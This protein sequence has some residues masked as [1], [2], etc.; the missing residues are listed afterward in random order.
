MFGVDN[1]FMCTGSLITP[2]Y[3]IS[4]AHCNNLV[5]QDGDREANRRECVRMTEAGRQYSNYPYFKHL[6][7]KCK[8]L[9]SGDFEIRTE[10]KG[11]AWMGVNDVNR[12]SA[13]N[14]R[15]SSEI[16]RHIRHAHSYKGGGR[17]GTYGGHDITLLELES[18]FAE[19]Q[20]V[21]LPSSRFDDTRLGKTD[22]KLAGYGKYLR[23][24]GKTCETNRYGMM[25]YHYC[26]KDYG[27]GNDAC[28]KDKPPP[29]SRECKAFFSNPDTPDEIPQGVEEINLVGGYKPS[30]LC[31]PSR[32]PENAA[33]GWC[34][35]RGNYYSRDDP[36][37]SY[38]RG[39]GFC[40]KDC[41]LDTTTENSGIL[42]RKD[43]IAILPEYECDEFL[44]RSL[45]GRVRYRPRILCI[46]MKNKWREEVWERSNYGFQK[47]GYNN[48]ARRYEHRR[49]SW[50]G[51]RP[52]NILAGYLL[53][54]K[55][56]D[57]HG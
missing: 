18:P 51:S 33:F 28:I 23:S 32:N 37:N 1:T 8:F 26:D 5:K 6:K 12:N 31:F 20:M 43:D 56:E 22:T 13:E 7:I 35:T 39:W 47:V 52:P 53:G 54:Q 3:F 44:Q 25:K 21:C 11:K 19:Y 50:G 14:A 27:S 42:R 10:P 46:A 15:H 38:R 17:Y 36:E 40:S 49:I 16:K 45:G 9:K 30:T 41:Y 57:F 48:E 24:E 55:I 4:A 2:S 34:R 29:S